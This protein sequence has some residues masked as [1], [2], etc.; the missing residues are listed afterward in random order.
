MDA[1]GE[2]FYFA[3]NSP[4]NATYTFSEYLRVFFVLRGCAQVCVAGE[5]SIASEACV[6][7]VNAFELASVTPAE[8]AM[9]LSLG[10]AQDFIGQLCPE[11]ATHKIVCKSYLYA[12][13]AQSDFDALRAALASA[14]SAQNK[15][16]AASSMHVRSA[17]MQLLDLLLQGYAVPRE[18]AQQDST[19]GRIADACR[20]INAHYK[21]NIQLS[22]LAKQQ[23]V[24]VSYLSRLF[25][26]ELGVTFM[27]YLTT[28]RLQR[29]LWFL[30][31]STGAITDIAYETGFKNTNSFIDYFKQHYQET[32]G[33][34]RKTHRSAAPLPQKP[35]DIGEDAGALSTAF[36][37]LLRYEPKA[38]RAEK[39]MPDAHAVTQIFAQSATGTRNLKH[40]WKRLVNVGYAKDILNAEVQKQLLRAQTEIGFGFLRAHGFLDDD[41]MVY[42]E[43]ADGTPVYNFTYLDEVLDFLLSIKLRPYLELSFMPSALAKQQN[44]IYA[45]KSII[46]MPKSL[47]AW[48]ALVTALLHH[49]AE[50]YGKAEMREWLI[51]PWGNP[52]FALMFPFFEAEDY[53]ALYFAS[54]RAIKAVDEG[55]TVVGPCSAFS[56][57]AFSEQ[58]LLRCLQE[59][60]VPDIFACHAYPAASADEDDKSLQLVENEEA[61]SIVLSANEQY[62]THYLAR[63]E[64]V[65]AKLGLS[66][67]PVMLDEWNS[68]LWQRDLCNDTAFKSAYLFKNILENYD[69]FY[70][71]GYWQLSDFMEELP[72]SGALFHGGFG[73][74]TRGGVAKSGFRALTLLTRM[75]DRLLAAGEGYFVTQKDDEIQVFLY[76]Y[77]H[78]DTLY[79][80][81]QAAEHTRTKRYKVFKSAQDRVFNLQLT[82]VLD[83]EWAMQRFLVGRG[84]GSAYD[85]WLTMGAPEHMTKAEC[86][87]LDAASAP[88]FTL[89]SVQALN[90]TLIVSARLAP[91]D[92]VVLLLRKR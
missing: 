87:Q 1:S 53:F 8:G 45:R 27:E 79:R 88:L 34:Y 11:L 25:Q 84:G 49:C 16:T 71:M 18:N 29:A 39:S 26:K 19:G 81:R 91:H 74:F 15:I 20:F 60:C 12:A 69:N 7:V 9:V 63:L 66:K 3:L 28:V 38:A 56:A 64:S 40:R 13:E 73:L 42:R 14:F 59:K 77:C 80:Y 58:F 68:N 75:G 30:Q 76:N 41:M 62:L 35:F 32:P 65:L 70:A 36:T 82:G 21:E 43:R 23:Y 72:P 48:T 2:R 86:A 52:D 10:L 37:T 85:L 83:G 31:N 17:I 55:L 24:S 61:F 33:Q 78:Y 92:V 6:F 47:L 57:I 67:L 22:Q 54:Y 89:H 5:G 46:S 90:E 44:S 4:D 51:C 50:R